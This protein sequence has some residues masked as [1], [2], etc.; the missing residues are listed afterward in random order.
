MLSIQFT[1][2]NRFIEWLNEELNRRGWSQNE[3]GR[4]SGMSG[5]N[6][7]LVTS[8]KQ[9]ITFDF[10]AAVAKALGKRPEP[11]F[12]MAGLI[13][14]FRGDVESVSDQEFLELL[15]ALP[16]EDRRNLRRYAEFL[17]AQRRTAEDADIR[18][19][20]VPST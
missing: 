19:A 7:S 2:M 5:A 12:R 14:A 18:T 3:L 20:S 13:P 9:K 10:V 4:R 8:G 17:L 1:L 6:V 16:P 11:L 15:S